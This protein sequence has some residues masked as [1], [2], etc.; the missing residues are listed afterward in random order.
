ML[1]PARACGFLG[2]FSLAVFLF[3][4]ANV[5]NRLHVPRSISRRVEDQRIATWNLVSL[6]GA[7]CLRGRPCEP[8]S[9]HE[10]RSALRVSF[11]RPSP[12]RFWGFR[13]SWRWMAG[14]RLDVPSAPTTS[15]RSRL[16]F[17]NYKGAHGSF[18]PRVSRDRDGRPL[19]SWRVLILPYLEQE[20]LYAQFHLDEPWDGPHN[21][22]LIGSMPSVLACPGQAEWIKNQ[23]LYQVLDGPGT[24]ST[25]RRQPV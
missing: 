22:A 15:S 18:P 23:T 10:S 9:H 21:R 12:R 19:L 5:P 14:F 4:L 17:Y 2:M 7:A 20:E 3:T 6:G 13:W 1:R 16:A 24:S 11:V 8:K 25:A